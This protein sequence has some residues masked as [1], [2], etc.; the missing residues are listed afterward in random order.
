MRKDELF[1][2]WSENVGLCPR[3]HMVARLIIEGSTDKEIAAE[4]DLTIHG[5]NSHTRRIYNRLG[6]NDRFKVMGQFVNY[7]IERM[8]K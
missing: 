3:E 2:N 1:Y 8:S 5:V 6:V 4:L 7:V